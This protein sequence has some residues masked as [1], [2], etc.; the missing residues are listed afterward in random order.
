[1]QKLIYVSILILNGIHFASANIDS[2]IYEQFCRRQVLT[3]HSNVNTH[4]SENQNLLSIA[5]NSNENE[6]LISLIDN[7]RDQLK[8][9]RMSWGDYYRYVR[10]KDFPSLPGIKD[11]DQSKSF[12]MI[13]QSMK[14]GIQELKDIHQQLKVTSKKLQ[15]CGV[16]KCSPQRRIELETKQR[17][18]RGLKKSTLSQN[19]WLYSSKIEDFLDGELDISDSRYITNSY[20]EIF[21]RNRGI[22]QELL[23]L[24]NNIRRNLNLD[25]VNFLSLSN[26]VSSK[27]LDSVLNN[28]MARGENHTKLCPIVQKKIEANKKIDNYRFAF[29][30]A[31]FGSMFIPH[32][33]TL[34]LHSVRLSGL[35]FGLKNGARTLL[36]L[37]ML[38][39]YQNMNFFCEN[40]ISNIERISIDEIKSCQEKLDELYYAS[41][42]SVIPYETLIKLPSL[43][44]KYKS[45]TK[46]NF[47]HTLRFDNEDKFK[48]KMASILGN[49]DEKNNPVSILDSPKGHRFYTLNMT[50]KNNPLNFNRDEYVDD[51]YQF[52][53]NIYGKRLKLSDK[54]IDD[55]IKSSK[56]MKQRSVIFSAKK[57]SSEEIEGGIAVV[58][59][60]GKT[61]KLPLEKA[62]GLVL[63][64]PKHERIVE[65]TRL[66]VEKGSDP[67]LF[68][69]FL[70]Q[71]SHYITGNNDISSIYYYTSKVH[72]R[73]YSKLGLGG[74]VISRPNSRDV[75]IKISREDL[76]KLINN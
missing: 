23:A 1:M 73:L 57:T 75:V 19:Y 30:V 47:V 12:E 16:M 53:A 28:A 59:S 2:T 25:K 66:T 15:I 65:I 63:D 14:D 32:P 54:E 33:T 55:F 35:M 39:Q 76:A 20:Y 71:V 21:N 72:H 29:D 50:N 42:L 6:Y 22:S 8:K 51:Y 18:L 44:N 70:E 68:Q 31:L 13:Y 43:Y 9:F 41:I 40:K 26:I 17:L 74:E 4:K 69:D 10:N 45:L 61:E 11:K 62:T 37:D 49:M 52:V 34:T 56:E 48:K 60:Q 3:C 58:H 64:R 24:K 67:K 7:N 5:T 38:N 46:S 36:T 27:Y